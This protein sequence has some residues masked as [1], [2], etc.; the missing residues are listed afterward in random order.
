MISKNPYTARFTSAL[1][2]F[3]FF[4]LSSQAVYS[5]DF[6]SIDTDLQILENLINDTLNK[7]T[8]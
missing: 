3:F 6:S 8:A 7:R 1:M 5:Q 2:F 4:S